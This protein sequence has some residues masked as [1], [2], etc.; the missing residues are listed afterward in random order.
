MLLVGDPCAP[1][2][3]GDVSRKPGLREAVRVKRGVG[4]MIMNSI[5]SIAEYVE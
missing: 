2:G 5:L 4:R 1:P 3:V